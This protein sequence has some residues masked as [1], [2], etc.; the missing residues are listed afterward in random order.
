[1]AFSFTNRTRR[2][3]P[4]LALRIGRVFVQEVQ[5]ANITARFDQA[6]RPKW[7]II[8]EDGSHFAARLVAITGGPHG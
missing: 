1:M 8:L 3:G 4:D 7:D 5:N 6:E 2:G